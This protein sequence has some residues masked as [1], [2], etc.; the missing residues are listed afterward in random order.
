MSANRTTICSLMI[1]MGLLWNGF[2]AMAT[3]DP[4]TQSIENGKRLFMTATFDGN[5][6]TCN[7]CH[8]GAGQ[9]AGMLP[10]GKVIPSLGNAAAIFPRY[11]AGARKVITLPQQVHRCVLGALQGTPP[12]YDSNA[13]AALISYLTSLSQ[14]KRI[15]MGESPQ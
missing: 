14:G 9:E 1:G 7:S 4:L 8:R 10:N 12:A 2:P 11:S 3:A 5:G 6:R 13:M 15:M